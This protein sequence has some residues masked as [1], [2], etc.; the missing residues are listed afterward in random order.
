MLRRPMPPH[1]DSSPAASRTL[2]EHASK[3]LLAGYGVPVARD[4]LVAT[5][6]EA[7][8]AASDLG[9]PVVLKLC[10]DAIAHKTERNL[11]RLGLGDAA[12]VTRAGEELLGQARAEDGD[13]GLLVAEQVHG[14]RELI[15]GLVRDPELGPCV[16]LG[17]GGI[18]TEALG[19]VVFASAPLT[20]AEVPALVRRLQ[21]SRLLTRPFRGEPALDEGV[22]AAALTGLGRLALER[23]DVVSVDL[24]PMIVCNGRPLAVD[25]LVELDP[26]RPVDPPRPATPPDA[27]ILERFRPLFHPRGIVIAGASSHPGKFGFSTLHNLQRFGFEGALFPVNRDGGE[28]LGKPT[29]SDVAQIPDDAA[30]LVVVCTPAKVNIGLLR[31]CAAKGVRGVMM[32]SAGYGEAGEEGKALE[33]ELV[34][35]VDELGMVMAGPNGQGLISTPRSMCAQ[36]VPPFP[37]TGRISVASQSGNL[38]SAFLNY[39]VESGIGISKAVSCGNSAQ[40]TLSDFLDYFAVDP[41]TAVALAYL[42]GLADGPHFIEA[43]RNLTRRKPFVFVK[44]GV[45]SE[46]QRAAASHTGALATDDRVFDGVARQLGALRAPSVEHAFEWAA[47][48]A[49]QPLPRGRRVVVFSTV[50]GWGVLAADA[51]AA[52]GLELVPLPDDVKKHIDALVPARWSRNNPIDLAG[53]E[54]RD[55]VPEVL[56]RVCGHPDVDAVIHLGIGIQ[57]AQAQAL[58]SGPFYPDHGLERIVGFHKRQDARYAEVAR[59]VSERHGKPVLTATELVHTD[60]AYGNAGPVGVKAQG[61]YCHASAHR[62]VTTLR[63][64]VDYAEFR[65]RVG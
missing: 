44:G 8:R 18:L 47:A 52:A 36:I 50:G 24:N 29:F 37:P 21:A 9:F 58:E 56:D 6:D 1:T 5:P 7:A 23:P 41:E 26:A 63:A 4:A 28:V 39:A 15:A 45:A 2:S 51:C 17:L 61:R 60:R 65:R 22:L 30:D 38:V 16:M 10:G 13:V 14:A 11:V 53:G 42:E 62:A 49:T 43:V 32:V 48:L 20:E 25:A 55:T 33:R 64:L 35:V 57:S 19:D 54:G 59:E 27:A 12:A 46:G 34:R 40:T 3:Q 31:A